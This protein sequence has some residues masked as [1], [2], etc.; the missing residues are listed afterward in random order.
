M[1][2]HPRHTFFRWLLSM[3][4]G[5]LL[6]LVLGSAQAAQ[7]QTAVLVNAAS[8]DSSVAPG[9]IASLFWSGAAQA[10]QGAT[11][12]PLPTTLAGVS[13]RINGLTAPLFYGSGSQINLQV[14]SGVTAGTAT[15][16]VFN[17]G[18][19]P[20]ATGTVTVV[21][22]A[23]GVFT[24]NSG[25]TGQA[26]VLNEDYS[27]NSDFGVFP[28]SRP[29]VS[30]KVVIIYATGIGNT[31]PL[32]ADG[33][34]APFSPFAVAVGTTTVTIGGQAA[35]VF[36]SGLAPGL[37]GLWQLNIGLPANLPTS[38][39]TTLS[40]TLKNKQSFQASLAVA[41]KDEFGSVTGVVVNALT[42]GAMAGA[43]LAL[44]PTGSGQTRNV[45]TDAL[46]RYSFYIITPGGYT[47]SA[48]SAGFLPASQ[49]ATITGG[50]AN[51]APPIALTAPLASSSQYRVVVTWLTG[52]DLDAHLTGPVTGGRFHVWWNGETNL[53]TP[54]TAQFDRDD[55]IGTGPETVTFTAGTGDYN[56]SVQNYTGRDTNGSTGLAQS[57]VAVR[58]YQG[59]QQVAFITAPSGGGTLWKVFKISNGV[60]SLVNQLSDETDPSLIKADF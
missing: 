47:L 24:I 38:M 18:G 17:G 60:F 14:P 49:S 45:T 25:G 32:V 3:S 56:F 7:A 58:V 50:Q 36:Y 35:T 41:N 22:S 29:E 40:V 13:V 43:N 6:A 2:S 9:S 34:A 4:G 54:V 12:I 27:Y 21:D 1:K 57:S 37:V 11:T 23:P 30:G 31:N 44:Q 26:V 53:L 28:G 8:Y 5:L 46:G 51:A 10:G 39:A 19:S 16:Q 48:S 15:V 59:N 55:L 42:G 52:I 20:A 33:Q